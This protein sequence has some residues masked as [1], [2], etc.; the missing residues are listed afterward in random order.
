M[1]PSAT[2]GQ[3]RLG[4]R[5]RRRLTWAA[6]VLAIGILLFL[7]LRPSPLAVDAARVTRGPLTVTVD[8]EG[9]TR[10]R[11]RFTIAAPVGGRL[12]RIAL[13]A[14]D[15]VAAGQVVARL[16]PVPLDVPSREQAQARVRAAEAQHSE[17]VAR[18]QQARATLEQTR[19]E[20]ARTQELEEAGAESRER[21]EIA[22][23]ALSNA[24]RDYTA[25]QDR[26]QAASAQVDAARAALAGASPTSTSPGTTIAVRAPTGGRVLR[27]LEPSERVVPSGTPLLDLANARALEV[28]ADVLSS[29]AVRIRPGNRVVIDDWGG[30][31]PLE[32]TVQHIEPAAFTRVSALGVEE[33]RVNI[34]IA[35]AEAPMSLGDGYRVEAHIVVWEAGSALRVPISALFR[36]GEGWEV[37]V[38]AGGRAQLRSVEL[39]ER[40]A[41]QAEVRGGLAEGDRV[42][43]YPSDQLRDGARVRVN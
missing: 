39:G 36:H 30:T 9:A 29:D 6:A 42:V 24:A 31:A 16:A 38:V 41:E 7:W 23:L 1:P 3:R 20:T 19:R 2:P 14:G 40:G 17:A 4:P 13:E 11:E 5:T 15:A 21:R 12:E 28:V 22:E 25:A 43:V 10:V 27:V 34:I 18:A 8:E 35:L 32:G 33:Q 26:V 37:F